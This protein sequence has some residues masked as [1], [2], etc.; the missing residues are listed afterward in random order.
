VTAAIAFSGRGEFNR[1]Q[2]GDPGETKNLIT[3]P[4]SESTERK[5]DGSLGLINLRSGRSQFRDRFPV[6]K[7]WDG[8]T[9]VVFQKNF[10]S[11]DTEVVIDRGEEIAGAGDSVD[12]VLSSLVAGTNDAAGL[13]AATSPEIGKGTGPMIASRLNRSGRGAGDTASRTG[14]L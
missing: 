4:F 1:P 7:D 2:T 13:D 8:S 5:S 14:D 9:G 11:I 3:V 6:R 10:L 12:D